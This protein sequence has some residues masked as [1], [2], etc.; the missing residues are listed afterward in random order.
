M[1]LSRVPDSMSGERVSNTKTALLWSCIRTRAS[2]HEHPWQTRPQQEIVPGGA[3]EEVED[4]HGWRGEPKQRL[5][6]RSG[7]VG[8]EESR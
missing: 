8:V 3:E 1:G 6:S 5:G 4:E 7:F 2:N